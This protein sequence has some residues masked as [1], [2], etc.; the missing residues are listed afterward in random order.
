[1]AIFRQGI[2]TSLG[3][4]FS[5][6]IVSNIGDVLTT[7]QNSSLNNFFIPVCEFLLNVIYLPIIV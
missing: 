5:T 1:M 6:D 7:Q 3:T 2:K 4:Q